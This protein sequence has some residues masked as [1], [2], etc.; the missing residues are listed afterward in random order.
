MFH[1]V[2]QFPAKVPSQKAMQ[3][4]SVPSQGHPAEVLLET[5]LRALEAGLGQRANKKTALQEMV[6]AGLG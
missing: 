5:K 4:L 2:E 6:Q 3:R 1:L